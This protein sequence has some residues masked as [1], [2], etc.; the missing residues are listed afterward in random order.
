MDLLRANLTPARL[1][2][3]LFTCLRKNFVLCLNNCCINKENLMKKPFLRLGLVFGLLA[4][5]VSSVF[6]YAAPANEGP[7]NGSTTTPITHLVVI[8]QENVSFDHYFGTY[9]NAL[10]SE[11]EPRFEAAKDTPTVN[12][13]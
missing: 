4:L 8:F 1:F 9:P 10:N 12:G 6:A 13:L 11:G 5:L 2:A 7:N 3:V